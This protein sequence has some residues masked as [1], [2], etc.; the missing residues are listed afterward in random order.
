M[1]HVLARYFP[2]NKLKLK[3]RASTRPV[4]SEYVRESTTR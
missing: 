3:L 1:V 2:L 4:Y